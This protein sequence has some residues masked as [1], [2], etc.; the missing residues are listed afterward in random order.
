M[1]TAFHLITVRVVEVRGL[2]KLGITKG[3]FWQKKNILFRNQDDGKSVSLETLNWAKAID[4]GGKTYLLWEVH[5][6][7]F[8]GLVIQPFDSLYCYEVFPEEGA[9]GEPLGKKMV[10]VDPFPGMDSQFMRP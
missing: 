4:T 9:G 10:K 7:R 3:S 1:S 5:N 8:Q 6:P 2:E